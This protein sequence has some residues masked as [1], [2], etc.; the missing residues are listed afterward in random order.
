MCTFSFRIATAALAVVS[1][2]ALAQ[3]PGA[4][5]TRPRAPAPETSGQEAAP[6]QP[7]ARR[8]ESPAREQTIQCAELSGK[9]RE[10]CLRTEREPAAGATR[11]VDP[12]TAPP[13]QNPR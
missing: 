12:P 8:E 6:K 7:E 10:D 13:P 11:P 1:C 3:A 5:E 9:Q 4:G 2:T